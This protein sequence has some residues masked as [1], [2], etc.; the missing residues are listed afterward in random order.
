MSYKRK[1][2]LKISIALLFL[3]ICWILGFSAILVTAFYM[4]SSPYRQPVIYFIYGITLGLTI[5]I[6]FFVYSILRS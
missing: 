2:I 1:K 5:D 4:F 3:I 6:L